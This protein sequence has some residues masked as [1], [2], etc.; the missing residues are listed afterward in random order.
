MH[1]LYVTQEKWQEHPWCKQLQAQEFLQPP[2]RMPYPD[3][4]SSRQGVHPSSLNASETCTAFRLIGDVFAFFLC[5]VWL[6]E[7]A[8]AFSLRGVEMMGT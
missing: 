1:F 7:A 6:A 4:P 3:V 5:G 2:L 8:P